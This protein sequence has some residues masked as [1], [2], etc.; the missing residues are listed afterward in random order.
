M[1]NSHGTM[2]VSND[3]PLILVTLNKPFIHN[4]L[5]LK[6]KAFSHSLTFRLTRNVVE[7][8][9]TTEKVILFLIY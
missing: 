5:S 4:Y 6:D 7:T 3:T 8:P 2:S 1:V 9:E